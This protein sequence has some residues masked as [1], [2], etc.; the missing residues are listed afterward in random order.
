MTRVRGKYYPS[1]KG[2]KKSKSD[3]FRLQKDYEVG[4]PRRYPIGA[5]F[6]FRVDIS[7]GKRFKT[8]QGALRINENDA[9]ANSEYKQR[10]KEIWLQNG[11][12]TAI[13]YG[14][15]SEYVDD[16]AFNVIQFESEALY[17]VAAK[18]NN[19]S[20][21][22][23]FTVIRNYDDLAEF[24]A[25]LNPHLVQRYFFEALFDFDQEY[26][27]HV[28]PRLM[29]KTITYNIDQPYRSERG[30]AW[31][32]RK[33]TKLHNNGV[34]HEV[35]KMV[36]QESH[37]QGRDTTIRNFAAGDT[38]FTSKFTPPSNWRAVQQ[39][40]VEA[41]SVLGLDFGFV[42]VL[43]NSS[44]G[45][46]IFC[47]SGSNPGMEN[48]PEIPVTNVTAQHYMIALRHIILSKAQTIP[49]FRTRTIRVSQ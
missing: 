49:K 27:I 34:I 41:I 12:P 30:G 4:D 40:A 44:T 36:R 20:G 48:S 37:D 28:S 18:L 14:K 8:R 25:N 24:L 7:F 15:L 6:P 39:N 47:E 22:K 42:D 35:R 29:G 10:C 21:G 33:I 13:S 19:S 5:K 23:G 2:R 45:E 11:V 26:R 1:V 43:Y 38:Y 9:I 31:A 17:P 3:M 32:S 46:Y 16:G